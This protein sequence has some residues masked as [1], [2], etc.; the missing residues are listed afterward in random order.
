MSSKRKPMSEETKRKIA[1]ANKGR[2]VSEETR[3]KISNSLSNLTDEQKQNRI[4]KIKESSNKT[5]ESVLQQQYESAKV[6]FDIE[7]WRQYDI[8]ENE[9]YNYI[10]FI[11][12]IQSLG[13]R[14]LEYCEKHH[15]VPKS[16]D[17]KLSKNKYNIIKLTAKEHFIA[18]QLL[19]E[20]F[21]GDL[22]CKMTL[23]LNLMMYPN[24][25]TKYIPDADTYEKVR[26]E[27]RKSRSEL[28]S[29]SNNPF[30]G[31]KHSE[32]SRKKM[33]ESSKGQVAWNKGMEMSDEYKRK[34]SECAIGKKIP[35]R[36]KNSASPGTIWITNEI[37]SKRIYPDELD[38]YI[39]EGWRRGKKYTE[40]RKKVLDNRNNQT[41][42]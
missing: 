21:I 22:K 13:D 3:K 37:T 5:R 34:V 42:T 33:S 7:Y 40:R 17:S 38:R 26:L 23:A 9:V 36:S 1:E 32:V 4:N 15:I 35:N 39:L 41:K 18:H 28:F 8:N 10:Q 29:G 31:H 2:V 14:N 16:V 25:T 6:I 11:K 30:Y 27:S 20:I 12:S 24:A 19:C